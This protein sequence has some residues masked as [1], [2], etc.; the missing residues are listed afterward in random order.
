MKSSKFK[1]DIL[2]L[3]VVYLLIAILQIRSGCFSAEFSDDEAS[4]YISGLLIHDYLLSGFHASPLGYLKWYHSHYPIV[5]IGHWGPAFYGIEALWMLVF[6]ASRV[7]V[8]LLS[9]VLSAALA[10]LVYGYAVSRLNLPR[11]AGFFSAAA[12]AICPIIQEGSSSVMLDIPIALLTFLAFY[13]YVRYFDTERWCYSVLFGL[14]ASVAM[15]IKGNGA[16]LALL[17]PLFVLFHQK[18]RLL[19]RWSFWAPLPLVGI[20]TVP[21]YYLTY[22]Q[23]AAG[24]RYSWGLAYTETAIV[25]NAGLLFWALGPV[26]VALAAIGF[27]LGWRRLSGS[28]YSHFKSLVALFVAVWIFQI[29]VPAA[30]QDRYLAPLLP[31]AFL[32][33]ALG[34]QILASLVGRRS[35]FAY[36]APAVLAVAALSIVPI[37]L[38]VE[39]KPRLGIREM[40]EQVWKARTDANPVVLIA[41]PEHVEAAA[42]AELAMIDPARPSLFAVRGSRLLGGG[43]YN[44]QDYL[45][46]FADVGEV[47]AQIETAHVPLVLYQADPGGWAHVAQVEAARL[48][49]TDPWQ[50]VGTITEGGA[51]TSV[52][53]LP[54]AEGTTADLKWWENLSAPQALR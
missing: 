19:G 1:T 31:S 9:G 45:P 27:V 8:L 20:L 51:T 16:L 13:A 2:F 30:I 54:Q 7:S 24:F 38:E 39:T 40:A 6:S 35:A 46:K 37:A 14:L 5:G 48:A 29:I 18:W 23:V 47:A 10:T 36:A 4:H 33:A 22:G 41:A 34:A 3:L 50:V 53:R 44:R 21:W 42:L 49:A 15:L 25:E 32:L 11:L 26:I 17:P 12:F 28:P 52:Y 43:G